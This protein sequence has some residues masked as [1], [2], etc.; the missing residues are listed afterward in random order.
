MA[1]KI[2]GRILDAATECFAHSGFHGCT[3]KTISD[4]ADCTEGSLFRLFGSKEKLFEA[5]VR[6]AFDAGRMPNDELARVLE[7]DKNFERGLRK[8]MLEFFDR[9]EESF[10]RIAMFA[11]L[12]RPEIAKEL[13]FTPTSAMSRV[14]SH[15]IEREIYRGNLRDDIDPRTAALQLVTS[16][17]QFAFI[18][19]ILAVDY[20]LTSREARRGAVKNFVEIWYHGMQK[21]SSKPTRKI[22]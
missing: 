21:Q 14:L 3:T 20:K 12:E 7:H 6:K 5:A 2:A 19:Q 11:L 8:G 10:I 17:W 13:M 9:I 4:R 1:S 18:S 22:A 15:S 16:L